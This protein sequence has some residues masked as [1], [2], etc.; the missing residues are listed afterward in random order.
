MVIVGTQPLTFSGPMDLGGSGA[1]WITVNNTANTT[2]SGV[3]SRGGL[4][5]NGAGRL[6][7]TGANTYTGNTNVRA[8][9]LVFGRSETNTGLSIQDGAAAEL[10]SG[11][12]KLL[13]LRTLAIAGGPAAP[14]GTLDLHDNDM[15]VNNA[16]YSDIAPQIGFARHGGAWDRAG[17]T[18]TEARIAPSHNTTLGTLTGAEFHSAQGP[19]ATFDG[20]PVNN[21][22][23][24]V[25]YTYYGDTDLNGRVNFDDYVRIDNGFNNHLTGWLNGDFDYNGQ[26]NFDDYVLIDLA[27]NTQ[28][29][30]LGRAVQWLS[31][32][33]TTPSD[34]TGLDKVVAHAGEF[35][36]GYVR[37]F[38]SAVPEPSSGLLLAT[39]VVGLTPRR[40]TKNRGKFPLCDS[41]RCEYISRH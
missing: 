32:D 34:G 25:K 15:I 40:R 4:V 10:A 27:F 31:G 19:S 33:G 11:G 23:V 26:V 12:D 18:S 2:I 29:G 37:S 28:S 5:K 39:V 16:A 21:T 9:T 24:L 38:L 36:E 3:I 14:A 35:G 7:L 22:D 13:S 1:R 30:T 41:G 17:I 8:G 6:I 20:L